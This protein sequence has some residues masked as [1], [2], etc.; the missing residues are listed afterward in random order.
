MKNV[1]SFL[2][3]QWFS[4]LLLAVVIGG[5]VYA[6]KTMRPRGSMSVVEA[7]AMDMTAMKAPTGVFPVGTDYALERVV[8]GSQSFPATIEAFNDENVVARVPGLVENVLVY[9]GDKVKA[10]QLLAKLSADEIQSKSNAGALAANASALQ[11]RAAESL[12]RQEQ[13]AVAR[14]KTE[15][16]TAQSRIQA[17]QADLKSAQ[18]KLEQARNNSAAAAAIIGERE[19]DVTYA[20]VNY[21]REQKLFEGGAISRNELDLARKNVDTAKARLAASR[22]QLAETRSNVQAEESK[23]QAAQASVETAKNS[24]ETARSTVAEA[25]ARVSRA[26]EQASA[27]RASADAVRADAGA[28]S[29]L[30]SYLE[31]RAATDGV[32]SE[33]TV[34]PGTPVM[35]GQT[36]LKLKSDS[37]LRVQAELPQ[38]LASQVRAGSPVRIRSNGQILDSTVSSVFPVVEGATR[39]FAVESVI[40]NQGGSW[41][42]GGYAEME[43]FVRQPVR[44]LSVRNEAIKTASDGTH[45]VW[46]VKEGDSEPDPDAEYTCTMHPEVSNNGPGLCPICK[47]DLV[48]RDARGNT[49]V[50]RRTVTTGVSDESYTEVESGLQAGDQVTFAGDKEL[51]PN[52]AVQPGE[53]DADGPIKLPAGSGMSGHEGH[54]AGSST[55]SDHSDHQGEMGSTMDKPGSP[56]LEN[57]Y[58]CPMHPE[59]EQEGP[60]TCPICKMDLVPMDEDGQ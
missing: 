18:A 27:A 33:R 29:T 54:D 9:P 53:W 38:N 34:S 42:I 48:P 37:R 20:E 49:F 28:S 40:E 56:E 41:S 21:Q 3:K 12:I 52:A 1:F 30:S 4:I 50:E 6:V 36:V 14:A 44:V 43:V 8:G 7:Q 13:A 47:M 59:V 16:K 5:T 31:L 25:E 35:A 57:P 15:I 51:F 39:T 24:L 58:T 32:V 2:A 17:S 45:Y 60:G 11:A 26:R 46:L 19:A 23:V 55:D 10:G 22:A